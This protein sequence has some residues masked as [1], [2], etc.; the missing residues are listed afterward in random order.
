MNLRIK[1]MRYAHYVISGAVAFWWS[2]L[3]P[4][5]CL[6]AVM[7]GGQIAPTVNFG[8]YVKARVSS[9]HPRL[10]G[11]AIDLAAANLS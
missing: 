9:L 11:I 7:F 10:C 2:R 8:Y 3:L 5:A 6:E 4:P 1:F